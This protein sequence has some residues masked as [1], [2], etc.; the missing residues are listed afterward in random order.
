MKFPE[1]FRWVDAPMGFATSE[2]TQHGVFIIPGRHANGRALK[3]I[4]TDGED[5][6]WE[7]VSVSVGDSLKKCASYTEMSLVKDLFW[8]DNQRVISFHPPKEEHVNM[9]EV[10]H[11]WRWKAGDFPHPPTAF[12]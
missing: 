12:V 8:D 6:E 11:L 9:G 3:V 2:G 7:H 10:L 1:Q 5:T 4:A